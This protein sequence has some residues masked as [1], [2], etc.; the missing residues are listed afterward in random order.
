MTIFWLTGACIGGIVLA[1]G[2]G[3]ATPW[4]LW[5]TTLLLL[6]GWLLLR[7]TRWEAGIILSA[8]TL[9]GFMLTN[10]ALSPPD[11]PQHIVRFAN[12]SHQVLEGRLQ[13][14]AV[15]PDGHSR[16]DLMVSRLWRGKRVAQATGRVRVSV[17]HG[18]VTVQEGQLLRLR[19][20]LRRPRNFGCPGEFDYT[21]HLASQ[22]IFVTAFIEEANQIVPIVETTQPRPAVLAN[23]RT[24]IARRID[25]NVLPDDAGLVKALLIGTRDGVSPEQRKQLSEGGVS[26]LFAI[27]GLHFGLLGLLLY[28]ATRRLYCCSPR[29]MLWCPPRRILPLLLIVPMGYYLLLT[30][31]ALPTRRAFCM[32][33]LAAL[34]Y[35]SNRRTP[36]LQLLA[37][38][39]FL[40]LLYQ[41]LALF[42]P[43][44]QLSFAGLFGILFWM[45]TWQSWTSDKP[46][47][48]HWPAVILL[49]TLAATIVTAPLVLW[50]FH[51]VA[52]AGLPAN[53]LAT[54]LIAWGA[55]PIGL[56]GVL[57]LPIVPECADLC[58]SGSGALIA[59]TLALVK[60]LSQLPGLTAW[61]YFPG[62]RDLLAL[63]LLSGG[64]LLHKNIRYHRIVCTGF[65]FTGIFLLLFRL[66]DSPALQV[67][68]LSV[69]QGDATLLSLQGTDHYLVDGGGLPGGRF[70]T[71]ERLVAPALGR[72]HVRHLRGVVLTHDH[73]DHRD[74]LLYIL[75]T[76]P[77]DRFYS[78]IPL[79]EL[80]PLLRAALRRRQIPV[81]CLPQGW[82]HVTSPA[83]ASLKIFTPTQTDRDKN[84]RSLVVYAGLAKDGVLL[85][86][87]MGP[88]GLRQLL[89]A[90]LPGSVTLF[91]LP[92]H[93]SRRPAPASYLSAIM[94]QTAFVSVGRHNVYHLPATTTLEQ[95]EQADIPL[96]RTDQQGTLIFRSDGNGWQT[97]P[98]SIG[99]SIDGT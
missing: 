25:Q 33:T 20:R 84:E 61:Y 3:Q 51:L 47:W 56:F 86:G 31:N 6:S 57:L 46:G 65:L 96:Y 54:P 91:K 90:G 37:A 48:L 19:I 64:L 38:T 95:L 99:F 35:S 18:L 11:D 7:K 73:P 82:S 17:G 55:L 14:L 94:P 27:S 30:G 44:F 70:D 41:P 36:V 62:W 80:D 63:L 52:P 59:T 66:G 8:T 12:D 16:F 60:G 39:G 77:V 26:H 68:A 10:L 5:T 43:A 53:L 76:F 58:F 29:L 85:T 98:A 32:A 50:H 24:I 87:D 45:P 15:Y 23:L 9:L 22:Q 71:G 92:H 79:A 13:D 40:I 42:R 89:Q 83:G 34:L 67:V 49:T 1:N 4:L 72:L 28:L 88:T 69:G 97:L 75:K 2:V 81:T 21:G 78:G 93:G 74:G